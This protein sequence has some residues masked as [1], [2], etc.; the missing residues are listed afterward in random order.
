MI[1][2]VM[3]IAANAAAGTTSLGIKAGM[4]LSSITQA[5]EEWEEELSYKSGF[6]GGAFLNYAFNEKFSLQPELLYTQK[7]VIGTLYEGFVDVEVTAS[8]DY[9]ELP[10]L[11]IYTFRGKEKFRPLVYA[12]PNIAFCLSSELKLSASILS[13]AVDFG[14]LTHVTD[15]G[16]LAGAGFGYVLGNG[17]LTFDARFQYGLTNVVMSGDFLINGETHTINVDDFKNITFYFMLGYTF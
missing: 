17:M 3:I 4:V 2:V 7:G 6:V 9:F 8:F 14:S 16:L 5:P 12:G 11:A 15:F 10:V 1:L 13:A